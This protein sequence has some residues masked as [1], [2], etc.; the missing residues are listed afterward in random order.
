MIAFTF[1]LALPLARALALQR[2]HALSTVPL[3]TRGL[4]HGP[5]R[6]LPGEL[7]TSAGACVQIR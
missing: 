3:R 4:A 2:V 5:Q 6:A 1:F 7:L